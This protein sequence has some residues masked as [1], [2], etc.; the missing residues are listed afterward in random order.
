MT[1]RLNDLLRLVYGR[2]SE[3]FIPANTNSNPL[4]TLP[5]TDDELSPLMDLEVDVSIIKEHQRKSVTVKSPPSRA[6]LPAHLP[7]VETILEP[8]AL[9]ADAQLIG[10]EVTEK[11]EYKPGKF[12]V[13][14]LI[15]RKYSVE[16]K[17][18]VVIAPMP[19]YPFPK[20]MAG[21]SL[22]MRILIDK[23]MDHLPLHRQIER[24]KRMGVELSQSTMCD[25]VKAVSELLEPLYDVLSKEI[26][27]SSYIGADET[28]VKVLDPNL[29]G[30]THTGYFWVYLSHSLQLVMFDYNR[31][32]AK[33]VPGE[34]LT[35]FKGY[36]QTDAYVAYNQFNEGKD[37]IRIG[38]MAH[39]RRKFEKAQQSNKVPTEE[40]LKL[41]Q[42]L[43]RIEHWLRVLKIPPEGRYKVRQKLSTKVLEQVKNLLDSQIKEVKPKTPLGQAIFYTIKQWKELIRYCDDGILEIDNNLVENKIRPVALGRKNYMFMGSHEGSRRSA[44]LYSLFQSC[45]LNDIN[46][47]EYLSD[48]L[49]RLPNTK[50]SELRS[51]LPDQWKPAQRPVQELV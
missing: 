31:S 15:R 25:W 32:R 1:N 43:Y 37:I 44:M 38:C 19:E 36:L 27:S 40:Y 5:F 35:G 16:S 45:A 10:E 47:E 33:S 9:P 4:P 49:N 23:Y 30:T 50:T 11:L 13:S 6:A 18:Q 24:Y 20:L 42:R 48:I 8:E 28:P 41:F 26:L 21:V 17:T 14:K 46:P 29:K 51:L 34:T 12:Y 22:L 7:R 2:K 39:A 3:R